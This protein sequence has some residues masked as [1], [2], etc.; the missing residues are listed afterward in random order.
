MVTTHEEADNTIVQQMLMVAREEPSGI[1]VL[2]DD[3]DVFA[4]LLH[5]YLKDDLKILVT[6]R[7]PMKDRVLAYIGSTVEKHK[8]IIPEILPVRALSGCDTV[9]CC[10]GIEKVTVLK[11]VRSGHSLSL[12]GQTNAPM[13]AVIKQATS[14]VAACY[15]QSNCHFMSNTRLNVW[16]AQT[17]KGFTSTPKLLTTANH[18][19]I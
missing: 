17:G 4:L 11:V 5:Y 2:S 8:D 9:A 10:F 6:M 3:T 12:L 19:S 15:G 7:S 18:R 13:P 16:A 1:T 14:F